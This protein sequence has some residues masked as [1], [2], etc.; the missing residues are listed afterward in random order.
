LAISAL[1]LSAQN[2]PILSP[3]CYL[4]ELAR[5]SSTL[6]LE[7]PALGGYV[8]FMQPSYGHTHAERRAL[9]FATV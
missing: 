7:A 5:Q 1:L 6:Y 2:D 3:E 4:Y 8:G 9:A